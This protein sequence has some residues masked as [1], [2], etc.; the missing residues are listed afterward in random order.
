MDE[1]YIGGKEKNKHEDKKLKAGRGTVG[2]A[3]VVGVRDRTTGLINTEVVERTDKATLQDFVMRHTT[4]STTVYTDEAAAYKGINRPHESVAHS[5]N[6]FVR[7]MAHT[8]GMESFWALFK[9]GIDG[10]Y[11]HV[12]VKHLGRYSAEFSG[13]HNDRP[14]DTSEQM[15][16]LVKGMEG[17]RLRYCD[18]IEKGEGEQDLGQ[19]MLF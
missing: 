8:N 15:E 1:T 3:P 12:S 6:E 18:L 5:A 10:T 19:M 4:E 13:R 17:K 2:K 16:V 7:E 11:H 9:R 14:L